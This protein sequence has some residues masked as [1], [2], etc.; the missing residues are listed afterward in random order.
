MNKKVLN[1]ILGI[2]LSIVLTFVTYFEFKIGFDMLGKKQQETANSI[3][4][5]ASNFGKNSA[6]VEELYV[7]E[8]APLPAE[9]GEVFEIDG[10]KLK[11]KLNGKITGEGFDYYG[12]LAYSSATNSLANSVN[13]YKSKE[14]VTEFKKAYND[15]WRGSYSNLLEFM[16]AAYVEDNITFY[17]QTYKDGNI[18]IVYN[19]GNTLYYM[20]I[21]TEDSIIVLSA[22]EPIAVTDEKVTVHYGDPQA[23][24][25]LS[26]TYSDYET[27]AA[28]NTIRELQEKEQ[29]EKE[30]PYT[31][32]DVVGTSAT[33]TSTSDNNKRKQLASYANYVWDEEGKCSET[34]L[35]ID[36]TSDKA[37]KSQWKI[38]NSAY[39]YDDSGLIISTLHVTRSASSFTIKG[40][41]TNKIDAERPYV[42][43]LKFLNSESKLLAVRVVDNRTKPLTPL[44]TGSFE[45]SLDSEKDKIDTSNI[46]IMQFEV[47]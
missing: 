39:S 14:N 30:N 41:V 47:Y 16:G 3:I 31:S 32:G 38:S 5:Y 17:Q 12:N 21:D 7:Y 43:V 25:M 33:Y 45:V 44:G 34:Q 42:V 36:L 19:A 26:H 1:T 28:E 9:D 2:L 37:I 20:F 4:E 8:E 24:P 11:V 22:P 46:T 13:L 35:S 27:L 23:N 10:Y 40:N 29:E 15:Y 18:P 6:S